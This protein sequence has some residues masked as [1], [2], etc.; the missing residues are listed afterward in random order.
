MLEWPAE[1]V[2]GWVWPGLDGKFDCRSG[3]RSNPNEEVRFWRSY[4]RNNLANFPPKPTTFK[5]ELPKDD[6]LISMTASERAELGYGDLEWG[7]SDYDSSGNPH[8]EGGNWE[9]L[10]QGLE[11]QEHGCAWSTFLLLNSAGKQWNGTVWYVEGE[12]LRYAMEAED[13]SDSRYGGG[14]L[15]DG[16]VDWLRQEMEKIDGNYRRWQDERTHGSEPEKKQT[17]S[18]GRDQYW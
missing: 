15:A 2:I 1:A 11:I 13:E 3:W 6:P 9:L 18:L 10:I 17:S 12:D 7:V 5:I 16:W 8:K 4:G 14:K